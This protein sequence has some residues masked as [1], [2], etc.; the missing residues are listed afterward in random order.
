MIFDAI[1]SLFALVFEFVAGLVFVALFPVINVFFALVEGI[2]GL[3][4]EALSLPR[5]NRS[6][7]KDSLWPKAV[8][9]LVL[10]LLVLVIALVDYKDRT[11]TL[12]GPDGHTLPFVS[13]IVNYSGKPN[14]TR[15]D[16]SGNIVIHRF[17]KVSLTVK[18]PRYE[19]VTL[20]KKQLS[21]VVIVERSSLGGTLDKTANF[22]IN[23]AKQ[24]FQK[25]VEKN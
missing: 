8:G 12:T 6:K 20:N 9:S 5:L 15:T 22:I 3:F 25:Q 16:E 11:I 4:I 2:L 21:D 17:G 1:F 7:S 19:E 24:A 14:Y 18:D 23:K 10:I 13:V